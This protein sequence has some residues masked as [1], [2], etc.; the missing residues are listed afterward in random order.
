[1]PLVERPI[2]SVLHSLSPAPNFARRRVG[3]SED[4]RGF[5]GEFM[6]ISASIQGTVP[7][8]VPLRVFLMR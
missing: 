2:P 1:M 5:Y 6:G 4:M 8:I 3:A 7:Y